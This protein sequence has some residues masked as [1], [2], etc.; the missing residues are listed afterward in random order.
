MLKVD[1]SCCTHG[2][3]SSFFVQIVD[4]YLLAGV[5][6]VNYNDVVGV[7]DLFADFID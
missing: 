2:F 4:V 5:P 7:F 6:V 1:D 3:S